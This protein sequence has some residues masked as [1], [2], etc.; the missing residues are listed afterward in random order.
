[1]QT[2]RIA[3]FGHRDL[4]TF[5]KIEE[6]LSDIL[7]EILQEKSYT[8]IY[9]G[10]NGEFDSLA[11]SV[12]RNVQKDMGSESSELILVLPYLMKATESVQS[13]YDS[14]MIPED[15]EGVHPKAAISRRNRFM[16]DICDLCIFYV[17]HEHGGAYSALKYAQKQ[18]KRI[19]NIAY[20]SSNH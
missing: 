9:I 19:I 4:Y 7:R 2:Y 3:L 16:V 11:A 10:R 20:E 17:E 15:L 12:I 5:R 13:K 6:R 1:M 18:G 8:E 14:I